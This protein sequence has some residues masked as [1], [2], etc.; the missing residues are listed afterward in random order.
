VAE[1]QKVLSKAA[2]RFALAAAACCLL[3]PWAAPA[4]AQIYV[5]AEAVD[6]SAVVLSN[7]ASAS[8]PQLL[9]AGEP[10]KAGAVAATPAPP[11]PAPPAARR[12]SPELAALI[13]QVARDV[14]VSPLLLHAVIAQESNFDPRA[15]SPKG[16]LG[17]MQLLP[18]TA[19]R[20][21]A[22]QALDP[23][24]NLRAGALYLR[25]LAELFEN[26]LD[27]VLAAY[28][29]GEQNVI[30]AGWQVPGFAE[31]QTYV[32]KILAGL[33]CNGLSACSLV[34]KGS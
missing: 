32:R 6:G 27:L 24:D 14:D 13:D 15:V 8:T 1:T 17:L 26:R 10:A 34:A 21:G 11:A 3:G 31:T 25:W 18:Q 4:R 20:F 2:R 19:S 16:A 7:F 33:R 28:N 22:R 9:L 29:A 5:S 12:A 23:R 30:R